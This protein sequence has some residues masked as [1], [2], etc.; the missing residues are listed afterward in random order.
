MHGG[1]RPSNR[2]WPSLRPVPSDSLSRARSSPSWCVRVTGNSTVRGCPA[3]T[4]RLDGEP[5]RLQDQG[6][7]G[8]APVAMSRASAGPAVLRPSRRSLRVGREPGAAVA[9]PGPKSGRPAT[10]SVQGPQGSQPVTDSR[11][12][13]PGPVHATCLAFA[14]AA[15]SSHGALRA[16]LKTYRKFSPIGQHVLSTVRAG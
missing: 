4:G 15:A 14:R 16:P 8:M 7:E 3:I 12:A 1:L 10:A 5:A 11:C 6:T 2:S 9:R 13:A